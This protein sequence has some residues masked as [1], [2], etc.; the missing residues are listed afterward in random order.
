MIGCLLIH[1][2]TGGPYEVEP[3]A[4]YLKERTDW[5]IVVPTLP[6]H[7]ET[8]ALRGV[9]H[10]EWIEH[11]EDQLKNLLEQ[12]EKVYVIG[13]SMGGLIAS[14]LTV[15]YNVDKLVLLSAAAYYVNIKQ[16]MKD[17]GGMIKEGLQG[18][19]LENELYNRY[20]F[21][22]T[23]T[24]ILSTYEFKKVVQR[25]R[26]LLH[27]VDVPTFIAQGEN[28]GI[29]PPKSAKYIYETI[30]SE[31]KNLYYSTKSKH[32]ICHSEDKHELFGE[33]YHFLESE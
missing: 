7:G 15:N 31:E 12:C 22:V 23:N 27:K 25:A 3:L 20:K 9:K 1:G 10:V 5:K 24:P 6:G 32:L 18:K 13:F 16:L 11:A 8:L 28:D 30:S 21:K 26:P 17:I 19:I 29:V 33:I 14:Y 4:D 2:F